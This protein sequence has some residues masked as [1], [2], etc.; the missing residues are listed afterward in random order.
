MA[1]GLDVGALGGLQALLQALVAR[2][3][4]L[5]HV[6][7]AE[8]VDRAVVDDAEHPGA[9][10]AAAAVV[11]GAGAPEREEGLLHDVLGD[12]A[13]ARDPVGEREGDLGV[14]LVEHLEGGRLAAADELHQILVGKCA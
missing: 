14:A 7:S 2:A 6:G 4:L 5:V 13:R 8:R 12:A 11:A 1:G 9:D 10:G 3:A